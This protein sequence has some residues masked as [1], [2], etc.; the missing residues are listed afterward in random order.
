MATPIRATRWA[1][2][3]RWPRLRL[4]NRDNLVENA[5][6][7][8]AYLL[9]RLKPLEDRHA[10]LGEVRGK[11]LMLALDLVEDKSSKEPV[12]PM[13]AFSDRLA[14]DCQRNGVIVRA[15]G[16]KLIVSPPLTFSRE[17]A[18]VLAAALDGAFSRVRLDPEA[19]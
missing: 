3:P 15:V 4:S 11:G 5:A 1:A 18:D 12:N 8:G 16:P 13:T 17:N 9:A 19:V 2:R 6:D 10:H 14:A 7:V